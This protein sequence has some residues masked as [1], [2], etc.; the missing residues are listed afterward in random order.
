VEVYSGQTGKK[1]TTGTFADNYYQLNTA[2]WPIGIYVVRVVRGEEVY[3]EKIQI[4]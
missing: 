2:G 3:T 1:M 4:K